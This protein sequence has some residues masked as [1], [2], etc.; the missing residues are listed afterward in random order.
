MTPSSGSFVRHALIW[1]NAARSTLSSPASFRLS[2]PSLKCLGARSLCYAGTGRFGARLPRLRRAAGDEPE[3]ANL[4]AE[5]ARVSGSSPAWCSPSWDQPVP[6]FAIDPVDLELVLAVDVSGSMDRGRSRDAA[7]R[8]LCRLWSTRRCFAPIR[9]G[10]HGRI[11]ATYVEWS[12]WDYNE[13]ITAW[14]LLE[15]EESVRAFS[16]VIARRAVDARPLYV[17]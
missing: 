6:S 1:I 17:H 2:A 3:G 14:S 15:D 11:V 12:G 10:Y 16:D 5:V 13:V 7:R 9:S 4:P 8:L